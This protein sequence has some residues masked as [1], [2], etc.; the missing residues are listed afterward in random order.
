MI[1]AL[2]KDSIVVEL[3][4]LSE[5]EIQSLGGQYELIIDISSANPTPAVGWIL[6]GN[7]LIPG[8]GQ[9]AVVTKRI[10]RLAMRQRFTFSEL[11]SLNNA[12][13]TSDPVAVL[14]DNLQSATYIDLLRPDTI[15][16]MSLLVSLG[17]ITEARKTVILEA[18]P[19]ID[20]I[21]KG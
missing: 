12:A 11:C 7:I 5:E 3:K 17:L 1:C 4:D 9:S 19:G 6:S 16:G 13:K 21:Y 10:T 8:E 2:V 20:E 15:G 18:T 14:M